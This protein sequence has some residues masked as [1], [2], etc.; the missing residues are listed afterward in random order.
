MIEAVHQ[1]MKR[2]IH[3]FFCFIIWML[4]ILSCIE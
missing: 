3:L 1:L 4:F 2:I